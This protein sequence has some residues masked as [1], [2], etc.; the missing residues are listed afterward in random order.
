MEAVLGRIEAAVL[1]G[2][3]WAESSSWR[4]AALVVLLALVTLVPGQTEL[5][6]TDRDES[7]YITASRQ[8]LETG[9][10]VDIRFQDDPRWKKPVGIYWLQAGASAMTGEPDA[11]VWVW[12]LPS[13][14]SIVA[15]GLLAAWAL[16]PVAGRRAAN[17]ASLMLVTALLPV[18]EGHLAKTDAALLVCCLAAMGALGRILLTPDKGFRWPHLVLWIALG[19]GVLIKG[20]IVLMPTA[21][22]IVWMAVAGRSLEPVW[23]VRILPGVL[24]LALV[25]LPWAVAIWIRTDGGFF[26]NAI[27]V[28]LLAKVTE[29]AEFH[30]GPPGYYVGTIWGTLWPWAPLILLAAPM[31]WARRAEPA[32][33]FLLGWLVP[34]WIAYELFATKLPHYVLPVFPALLGLVAIWI[35]AR[36]KETPGPGRMLLAAGLFVLPGLGLGL[37]AIL[38]LPLIE[39]TF[40][41]PAALLGV[42]AILAV[43]AAARAMVERRVAAFLGTGAIAA[44]AIYPAIL[45]FALPRLDTVF[46]SPR[47]AEAHARLGDCTGRPLA[48]VG[49][50]EPSL[51]VAAGTDTIRLT[52]DEAQSR[53]AGEDGWTI[54][55][56][57]RRDRTLQAFVEEAGFPLD[58]LATVSGF[59]YNRGERTAIFLVARE[60]DAVVARC[61]AVTAGEPR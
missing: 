2:L 18:V 17:L 24:I 9:D 61:R 30:W 57:E 5:P 14:L 16:R 45:H 32:T 15:A 26:R 6:P 35:A 22:A 1:R 55:V 36:E 60:D 59:N 52:G 25:A 58:I 51:V 43:A 3:A 34:F 31:A 19:A 40:S 8:M 38:G 23:R 11:P 42:L 7:R 50:Y 12:R 27:M 53:L 10:F 46:I 20:P 48:I 47:L 4:H 41:I 21:A 49:Y 54:F 33:R 29:G 13:M 39:G 44:L 37:A 56:E 28:D